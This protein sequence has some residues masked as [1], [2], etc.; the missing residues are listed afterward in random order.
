[1]PDLAFPPRFLTRMQGLLGEQYPAF[2]EAYEQPPRRGL[3]ANPLK[4][5][6]A[7]LKDLLG[8]AIEPAPFSPEGF[9]L[10]EERA[11]GA[12]PLHHAGAYYMQ[13]AS[14]MSAVT[15]LSPRPGERVLDLCAAPGGKSTQIAAALQGEGL[16]WCN[17]YVRARAGA[18]MQ[19]LER[20][21]VVNAVVTSMDTAPLCEAL[22]GGFDAVLCDAPCSGEGMFR[23][24]PAALTGWSEENIALC[25]RRQR[26]I[27][28]AAAKALRPGGR[29]LYS[30]C[31]F[32]PEENE[33]TAGW[34]LSAHPEFR[35]GDLS[36]LP[37]G[38]PAFPLGGFPPS[39]GRRI[40][41]GQGGEG[42]FLALFIKEGDE[43][44]RFSPYR[45][46]K[47]DPHAASAEA[48]YRDCFCKEPRGVFVTF[49]DTVRLLPPDLP[50]TPLHLLSAGVAAATVC[51]D[52]LEPTHSIFAAMRAEDCRRAV[53]LPPGAPE[54]KAFLRGEP[55]PCDPALTGFAAVAADGAVTG[56]G[57]A[58]NGTLK[59]RYPKGLRLL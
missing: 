50:D 52:R 4:L 13:E 8:P 20:L 23:K 40:L 24:E 49:N 3:R 39:A 19:N 36:R 32:A 30:T 38:Q 18:L 33:E 14:A 46:P 53:I 22:A 44:A 54:L 17:E 58:V 6:V 47:K 2:L 29:L 34:F 28:E 12:D 26:T 16:L 41:P 21:G 31:T 48:L 1:M 5:S 9:V 55:I 51:K 10:T 43:P 42:H 11:A 37:F 57:K 56:F 7:R 15:A 59:N 45:F 35:P 25:A 27:L